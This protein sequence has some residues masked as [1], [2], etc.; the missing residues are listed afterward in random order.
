VFEK[1]PTRS[2]KRRPRLGDKPHYFYHLLKLNSMSFKHLTKINTKIQIWLEARPN[3]LRQVVSMRQSRISNFKY[4]I[5]DLMSREQLT[6]NIISIPKANQ[7]S[8]ITSVYFILFS[9]SSS[10]TRAEII[11][12]FTFTTT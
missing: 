5:S 12:W 2:R 9:L 4:V 7:E 11:E 1:Y 6:A 10:N 8:A 3:K